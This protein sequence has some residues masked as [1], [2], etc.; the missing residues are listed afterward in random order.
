VGVTVKVTWE[1]KV[2]FGEMTGGVGTQL[3]RIK[4]ASIPAAS[5]DEKKRFFIELV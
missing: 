3:A 5:R 2:T 1:V 4:L